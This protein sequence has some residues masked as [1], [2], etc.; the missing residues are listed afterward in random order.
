M[1]VIGEG[2]NP[3]ISQLQAL[4]N[5]HGIK[6]APGILEK[7]KRAVASCPAFAEQAEVSRKSSKEVAAKI[8]L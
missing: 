1:L 3:G 8:N 4:G 7:V 5:Q 2:R 6:N